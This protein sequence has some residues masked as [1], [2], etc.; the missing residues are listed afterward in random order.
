MKQ[1]EQ[2]KGMITL[3]GQR[4]CYFPVK[5][6]INIIYIYFHSGKLRLNHCSY[7]PDGG[8]WLSSPSG[9]RQAHYNMEQGQKYQIAVDI[10]RSFEK[11]DKINVVNI[12]FF[13]QLTF[14]YEITAV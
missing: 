11:L 2:S 13:T 1:L 6:G 3:K 8:T 7:T 12:Q 5:E 4:S 10:K 9:G 14:E